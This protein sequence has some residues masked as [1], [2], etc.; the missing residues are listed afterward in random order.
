MEDLISKR[1]IEEKNPIR[2]FIER[3]SKQYPDHHL[4]KLNL[5]IGDPTH[6]EGFTPDEDV[7]KMVFES[8]AQ[9]TSGL[10]DPSQPV[11][12]NLK[13]RAFLAQKYSEKGTKVSPDDIII[14]NGSSEAIMDILL[15][16][17]SP[18][19]N[20]IY[21]SP[22][23]PMP[24]S[25]TQFIGGEC[26][27]FSLKIDQN[28][29]PDFEQME[30]LIDSRTKALVVNNPGNPT[31]HIWSKEVIQKLIS[32][33]EK[34]R[35]PIIS[36]EP[37]MKMVFPG[38][39]FVSFGDLPCK[40]PLMIMGSGSKMFSG[41][42]W[43]IGWIIIKEESEALKNQLVNMILKSTVFFGRTATTVQSSIPGF[44]EKMEKSE[45]QR[46]FLARAKERNDDFF[47]KLKN[48]KGFIP[49][50]ISGSMFG[51]LKVDLEHF[52]EFKNSGKSHW[53]LKR[54][55]MCMSCRAICSCRICR[56]F[57]TFR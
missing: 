55:R 48:I 21:H 51:T 31:G 39:T 34:H 36:D 11:K 33:A 53:P 25:S 41:P 18:G 50:K 24:E 3:Y 44:W 35:I 45:F 16:L 23:F 37:Y 1:F 43:R 29:E 17:L 13:S 28:W 57:G 56:L 46:M 19:D 14:T 47:E 54:N 2:A 7:R 32:V 6:Y 15:A 9:P 4:P 8:I 12:G 27:F 26:R 5:T 49:G 40:V 22:C 20:I 42:G 10:D 38:E 30:P 52:T